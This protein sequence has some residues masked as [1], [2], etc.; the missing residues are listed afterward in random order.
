MVTQLKQAEWYLFSTLMLSS[1]KSH[2]FS[3]FPMTFIL[4]LRRNHFLL[5]DTYAFEVPIVQ[6]GLNLNLEMALFG[7]ILLS[8]PSWCCAGSSRH[9]SLFSQYLVMSLPNTALLIQ[10][11]VTKMRF[12]VATCFTMYTDCH[13]MYASLPKAEN[14]G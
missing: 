11:N 9:V 12:R 13:R 5:G 1:S 3:L 6:N 2:H 10:S 4:F 7:A 14:R 8:Q